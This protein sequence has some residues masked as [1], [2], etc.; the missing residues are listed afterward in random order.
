M[1][2]RGFTLT[3]VLIALTVLGLMGIALTR[4]LINESRFVSRQE[5]MMSAR[6]ASRAAMN[7]AAEE[8]RMV[9]DFGLTTASNKQ[10]VLRVPYAF[11]M[12]CRVSGAVRIAALVPPDS[13]MYASAVPEGYQW[14][15]ANDAYFTAW[16]AT[17]AASADVA[18]C[19]AD[20]VRVLPGGKLIQMTPTTPTAPSGTLFF[21]YQQ[22][23]YRFAPSVDLPGRTALWRRVG[24]GVDEELVAPFDTSSGFRFLVGPNLTPQSAPPAP[25]TMTRGLELILVGASDSP[26]QGTPEPQK[27]ELRTRVAFLNRVTP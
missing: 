26:A 27:F 15:A 12:M 25:L 6:Q 5:T 16:P 8:I 10:I 24:A 21:L 14:R 18:S 23:R 3:E 20:S 1:N 17:V 22:V 2:R 11:G 9:A 19:T 4:V 13:L 7:V